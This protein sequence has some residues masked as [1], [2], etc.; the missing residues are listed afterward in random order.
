MTAEIEVLECTSGV[1]KKSGRPYNIVLARYNGRVGKFF[2]DVALTP[3][4]KAHVEF[5]IKPGLDL[6]F[7]V[8]IAGL[9]SKG[10]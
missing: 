1:G 7:G 4:E 10:K 2:S 5:S 6:S 3:G 9:A 8:G